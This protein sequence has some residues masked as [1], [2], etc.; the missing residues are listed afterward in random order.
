MFANESIYALWDMICL[1]TP[2]RN[3]AHR[4]LM[5]YLPSKTLRL[6]R[7]WRLTYTTQTLT[8]TQSSFGIGIS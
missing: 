6:F 4:D 7:Y 1:R 2:W 8:L 5:N 3:A